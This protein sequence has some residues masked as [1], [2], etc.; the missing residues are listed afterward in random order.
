MP[1]K[2]LAAG[3]TSATSPTPDQLVAGNE[4]LLIARK[5]ILAAG[6]NLTRGALLGKVSTANAATTPVGAVANSGVAT[7]SAISVGSDAAEGTYTVAVTAA[8]DGTTGAAFSVTGPTGKTATGNM[9]VA[10]SGLS[11]GFTV[12]DGAAANAAVVG[13]SYTFAVT[14]SNGEYRLS[15]S[16]AN[17]GSQTPVAILVHDTDATSGDTET[18]IYER[19]D[20]NQSAV[21]FGTGHT[22]ESVR[23]GLRAL[24]IFFSKPY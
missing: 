13:D 23:A 14:A 1:D 22:A 12:T 15:L 18:L 4:A 24:G 6:Q 2:S 19:G 9:G 17:D 20:F 16:A 8:K 7:F 21:T 3:V 10:F 5:A 11:L